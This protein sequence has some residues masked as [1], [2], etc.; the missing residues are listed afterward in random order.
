MLLGR[1]GSVTEHRE[2]P[3]LVTELASE[4]HLHAKT[5]SYCC[6]GLHS[7]ATG[8]NSQCS[9]WL[10]TCFSRFF[11]F[12]MAICKQWGWMGCISDNWGIQKYLIIGHCSFHPT[13]QMLPYVWYNI[14]FWTCIHVCAFLQSKSFLQLCYS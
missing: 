8:R 13:F 3:W 14:S 12:S 1:I 10:Q 7:L 4:A 2:V 11:H 6:W 9:V 5:V